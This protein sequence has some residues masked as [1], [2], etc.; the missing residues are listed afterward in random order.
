[1]FVVITGVLALVVDVREVM[2]TLPPELAHYAPHPPP[3]S[4]IQNLTI[5]VGFKIYIRT[6]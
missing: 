1:M 5:K 4:D 6:S 2:M 3:T